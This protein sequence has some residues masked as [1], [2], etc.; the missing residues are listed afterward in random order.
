MILI[1]NYNLLLNN[2]IKRLSE[3]RQHKQKLS[4]LVRD[5]EEELEEAMSKIDILRQEVRRSEKLRRELESRLEESTVEI[6]NERKLR[7]K[8]EDLCHQVY[9]FKSY[10]LYMLIIIQF[11]IIFSIKLK[12]KGLIHHMVVI[13]LKQM[14]MLIN[15]QCK[16]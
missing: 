13:L 6:T 1:F 5:K 4:R 11:Y 15:E 2:C 12:L 10:L 8:N 14:K 9:Y 7:E 3:L 16:K